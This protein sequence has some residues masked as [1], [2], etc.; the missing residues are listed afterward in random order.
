MQHDL[1]NIQGFSTRPR[2]SAR[3]LHIS[4]VLVLSLK[5]HNYKDINNICILPHAFISFLIVTHNISTQ[6]D[7]I[8]LRIDRR[9]EELVILRAD[10]HFII[11]IMRREFMNMGNISTSIHVKSV[12][13]RVKM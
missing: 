5:C 9:T 8:W 10:T 7:L 3:P 12:G 2:G 13:S 1:I 11:K 4:A 6:L